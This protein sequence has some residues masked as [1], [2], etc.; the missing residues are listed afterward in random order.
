MQS[1]HRFFVK[2][3]G[4]LPQKNEFDRLLSGKGV[5]FDGAKD[6]RYS[7]TKTLIEGL[8]FGP[9]Q[10]VTYENF[11]V[12]Q[13]IGRAHKITDPYHVSA[14]TLALRKRRA[15]QKALGDDPHFLTKNFSVNPKN[16]GD[17]T[18]PKTGEITVEGYQ[19]MNLKPREIQFSHGARRRKTT[20]ETAR[21]APGRLNQEKGIHF[22]EAEESLDIITKKQ[23]KLTKGKTPKQLLDVR[24]K[25]E[26][27]NQE[28][29]Y[30][31]L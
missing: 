23:K 10:N 7:K 24:N 27:L 20:K 22:R 3:N 21:I 30:M 28:K 17:I 2:E 13:A 19:S 16:Y 1:F 5:N 9:I 8:K 25:V 4:R 6:Y 18:D 12:K 26:K 31:N 29:I 14:G 15:T 11:L